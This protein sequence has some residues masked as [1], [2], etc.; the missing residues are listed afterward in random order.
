MRSLRSE[1]PNELREWKS[2]AVFRRHYEQLTGH[3]RDEEFFGKGNSWPRDGFLAAEFARLTNARQV[4]LTSELRPDFCL[5][6]KNG[7]C[8]Q[9]E[10]VEALE[11]GRRRGDE[12]KERKKLGDVPTYGSLGDWS[13]FRALVV[14]ALRKAIAN[15]NEKAKELASRGNPYP[16]GT[17]LFVYLNISTFGSWQQEI[18][19]DFFACARLARSHFPVV[20]VL[21]D[22]KLWRLPTSEPSGAGYFRPRPT[23]E[24]GWAM[25]VGRDTES[26][27]EI[28]ARDGSE[29]HHDR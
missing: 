13:R 2:T 9:I 7:Q 12:I 11:L 1:V 18:S 4:R 14:P 22:G 8:L 19:A 26:L 27:T 25:A 21:W 20:W 6:Y 29:F 17:Q 3:L 28:F 23:R 24:L 5:E 10:A 16:K 15:K